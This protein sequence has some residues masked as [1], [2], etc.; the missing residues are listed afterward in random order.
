[1]KLASR[2]F[3]KN[4]SAQL[5]HFLVF[6]AVVFYTQS[7]KTQA[8]IKSP[9]QEHFTNLGLKTQSVQRQV[10]TFYFKK[11]FA[12]KSDSKYPVA[13]AK[14]TINPPDVTIRK[15]NT[16]FERN[17]KAD[18]DTSGI[19]PQFYTRYLKLARFAGVSLDSVVY[20]KWQAD[21]D[22]KF[23]WFII[24]KSVD[25]KYFLKAGELDLEEMSDRRDFYF[26]DTVFKKEAVYYYQ[27]KALLNDGSFMISDFIPVKNNAVVLKATL[28]PV[29]GENKLLLRTN[30]PVKKIEII[31]TEGEVVFRN[32]E[33]G[34]EEIVDVG[35]LKT[36]R[37]S[38]RVFGFDGYETQLFIE[39]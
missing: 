9:V 29:S 18:Q 26:T 25:R 12:R 22:E 2:D 39:R 34:K 8:P 37:Y 36:G 23:R 33:I 11:L 15:D 24:E 16:P 17:K 14:K 7:A 5:K 13:N 30:L 6:A 27:V 38:L 3:K 32:K 35:F 28:I 10:T 20:L 4:K 19:F 21:I 1:M 31:N